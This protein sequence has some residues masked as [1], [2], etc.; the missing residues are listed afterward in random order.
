MSDELKEIIL[1]LVDEIKGMKKEIADVKVEN[2]QIKQAARNR[3]MSD[4]ASWAKETEERNAA[5]SRSPVYNEK[6]V[7]EDGFMGKEGACPFCVSQEKPSLLD[8]NPSNARWECRRC[9]KG[10]R[11][12]SLGKPYSLELERAY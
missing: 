3:P 11:L 10:W 2:V 4:L 8:L 1:S 7:K 6:L 12:D 9:G 5:A